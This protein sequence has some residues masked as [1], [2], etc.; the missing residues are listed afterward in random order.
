MRPFPRFCAPICAPRENWPRGT[1]GAQILTY[2]HVWSI[3]VKYCRRSLHCKVFF[4]SSYGLLWR[5]WSRGSSFTRERSK[6][7][8][9]VRPPFLLQKQEKIRLGLPS[10]TVPQ[11][12]RKQPHAKNP[13]VAP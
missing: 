3:E 4:D 2:G 1:A 13:T 8:S 11:K 12:Y 9:L 7:R 10:V 5:P 6:V